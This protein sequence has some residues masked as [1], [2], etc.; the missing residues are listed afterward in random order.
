MEAYSLGYSLGFYTDDFIRPRRGKFRKHSTVYILKLIIVTNT[1]RHLG[2]VC[3]CFSLKPF[4]TDQTLKFCKDFRFQFYLS[5][6]ILSPLL[7]L[8]N[9][10]FLSFQD[11]DG[12]GGREG[13]ISCSMSLR[14]LSSQAGHPRLCGWEKWECCQHF[15]PPPKGTLGWSCHGKCYQ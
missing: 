13:P 15:V 12:S 6:S 8:T 1:I 5:V 11:V 14:C 10:S 2:H 9:V 7:S 4:Q 3:F